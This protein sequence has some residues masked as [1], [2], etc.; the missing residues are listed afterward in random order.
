[1]KLKLILIICLPSFL[2]LNLKAQSLVDNEATTETKALYRNLS[3]LAGKHILFGQQDATN[4]G[5]DWSVGEN[6]SDIKDVCGS[7]PAMIGDDFDKLTVKDEKRLEEG[8]KHLLKTITDTYER[9][10]VI[11]ICWHS[12]NPVNGGSFYWEKNPVEAVA[13]ILPGGTKHQQY[14][15][16]LDRIAEVAHEAKGKGGEL[17]PIIFRPFHEFDGD[18]F[19]WGSAHCTK[20]EF[21]CLWRFTVDYLKDTKL[22]HNFLYAFSPDC[23]FTTEKEYLERYPGDKYVDILG[24][25]NYWDFRPDGANH[26]KLAVDKLKIVSDIAK[27]K[28]KLAALTETGL[29]GVTNPEWYTSVLLP[30]LK[31]PAIKLAYVMVWRNANY[32]PNHYYAPFSGHPAEDDFRKFKEDS[33]I[34]FEDRL[35]DLYK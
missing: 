27:N 22:V 16:Y 25:D 26:P 2:G 35:P 31:N 30:I 28:Q 13:H 34:Y 9:G 12:V 15:L 32:N 5:H 10:G 11:T 3:E 24:T 21:I 4:Y 23:K 20:K 7:H 19:W 1:M 18:W 33:Q 8:R 6:R 29:E 14:L 17:I